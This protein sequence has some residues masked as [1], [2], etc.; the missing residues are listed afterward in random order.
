[1][2]TVVVHDGAGVVYLDMFYSPN[3]PA[4]AL[5]LAAEDDITVIEYEGRHFF[6]ADYLAGQH[7]DPLIL[8]IIAWMEARALEAC[9]VLRPGGQER[10]D[11]LGEATTPAA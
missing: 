9:A 11:Y 6:P 8:K 4:R 1:M 10:Y 5:T 2:G 3:I 7:T